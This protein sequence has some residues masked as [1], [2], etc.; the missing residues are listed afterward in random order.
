MRK[1]CWVFFG[2]NE[3]YTAS[4]PQSSKVCFAANCFEKSF[5]IAELFSDTRCSHFSCDVDILT[6]VYRKTWSGS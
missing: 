3:F 2:E 4:C 5:V 6:G 1:V